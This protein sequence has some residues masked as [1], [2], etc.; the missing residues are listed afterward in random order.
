MDDRIPR[1]RMV[2][3]KL[4]LSKALAAVGSDVC[5]LDFETTSLAPADGRVRLVSLC[6]KKARYVVDFDQIKGGFRA[7]APMF[8]KGHWV[9]FNAG[10]ELRWFIDA[11]APKTICL[12]VG[13]VR[14]AV[15]GGGRFS[16]AQMAEWDLDIPMDKTQQNSN[17]NDPALTKEQLDYAF[18]DAYRTWQLWQH[19]GSRADDRHMSGF[20]M[21]NDMVPAVIEME[22]TGVLLDMKRHRELV[23]HWEGIRDD[24]VATIRSLVGEDEVENI[25]SDT[26]WSDYFAK[27]MPPENLRAWPRTEKSGQ[28]SMTSEILRNLA[29]ACPGTPLE[30]FFDALADYKKISK[31]LSSFGEPLITKATLSRDKRIRAR[32]NIGAAKT[33]RFSSSGPNLQQVPRDTE[34]LGE[35]TSVRQSFVAGMG[36]QLVS[37]DYSAIELRVLALLSNDAQL[38]EDVVFGDLHAEVASFGAGRKIDK[39]VPADKELR[40]KAKAVSFGIIYGSA[41]AGLSLTMR[42]T[43]AKAQAYIDFWADRYTN[44][45]DYRNK[46]M[47]E[48]Q[49]TRH[50]RCVDGGTIYMGKRPDLPK[51]ANYPVQRAAMAVLAKALK[52]HKATMDAERAAGRQR[53]TRILATIHDALIDEAGKKDASACYDLMMNDMIE[54]YLDVF[55]GAPIEHLVEGGVGPNWGRL[56]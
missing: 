45:F 14:R 52:R 9:V 47:S 34:L 27:L 7:V 26:Q 30:T 10:F 3:T 24:K 5:A 17:W 22:D 56:D 37:L 51:C 1:Y 12:D 6:N 44:A 32:F 39:S 49:R 31:Y 18:I 15:L 25:N 41:A 29:G 46:M 40:T 28:L 11:G 54:G 21:M 16:L 4:G 8:H 38:L 50:I 36:R 13:Y 42:T 35:K 55:P 20:A 19:W 53:M 23:K 48:A 2:S 43:V 33:C